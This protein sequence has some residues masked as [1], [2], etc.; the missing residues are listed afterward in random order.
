MQTGKV[1][2]GYNWQRSPYYLSVIGAPS[3]Y[4]VD[5]WQIGELGARLVNDADDY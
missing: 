4:D 1:W 2:V 3:N 5:A